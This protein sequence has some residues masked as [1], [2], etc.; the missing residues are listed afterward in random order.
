MLNVVVKKYISKRIYCHS[1]IKRPQTHWMSAPVLQT[2]RI[3][4]PPK[5]LSFRVNQ[6]KTIQHLRVLSIQNTRWDFENVDVL[7]YTYF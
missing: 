3:I 1:Y 2:H 6:G 5:S 7:S 4:S